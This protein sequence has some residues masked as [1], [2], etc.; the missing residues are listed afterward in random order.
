VR[1]EDSTEGEALGF[2]ADEFSIKEFVFNVLF[3]VLSGGDGIVADDVTVGSAG[4][5]FE[6]ILCFQTYLQVQFLLQQILHL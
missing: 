6:N 4:F 5:D 1:S 2:G 3:R